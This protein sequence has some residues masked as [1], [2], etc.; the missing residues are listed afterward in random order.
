[1]ASACFFCF[2]LFVAFVG[3]GLSRLVWVCWAMMFV[4]GGGL[5]LR[6]EWARIL[7][8][9][10]ASINA[11]ILAIVSVGMATD[12]DVGSRRF[13]IYPIMGFAIL[14]GGIWFFTRRPIK[15]SFH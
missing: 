2:T 7:W 12:A 6:Q 1:M 9:F 5:L 4:A 8:G 15:A 10:F 3:G 13:L 14:L 11:L